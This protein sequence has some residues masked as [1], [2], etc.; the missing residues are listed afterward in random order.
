M[1]VP[2]ATGTSDNTETG[3]ECHIHNSRVTQKELKNQKDSAIV[4]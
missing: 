4:R 1:S 3:L 2:I